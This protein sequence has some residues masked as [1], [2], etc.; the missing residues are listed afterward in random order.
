M[1]HWI[2]QAHCTNYH[3]LL[4]ANFEER[5]RDLRGFQGGIS[6]KKNIKKRQ[7]E[8]NL[9]AGDPQRREYSLARHSHYHHV[10]LSRR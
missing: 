1:M 8:N 6:K 10:R 9:E 5:S 4:F 7:E 3:I 2:T